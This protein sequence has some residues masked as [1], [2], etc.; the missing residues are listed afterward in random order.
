[1]ICFVFI[2]AVPSIPGEDQ[3]LVLIGVS[4]MKFVKIMKIIKQGFIRRVIFLCY[5][6]VVSLDFCLGLF[7]I[8]LV[9][10]IDKVEKVIFKFIRNYF[11]IFFNN[12][13]D[14]GEAVYY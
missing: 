3:F 2:I 11:T 4:W 7:D 13:N 9:N 8:Y 1:M 12:D 10:L 5:W 14:N 6:M